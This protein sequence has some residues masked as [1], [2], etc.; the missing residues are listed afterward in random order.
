[1]NTH[2]LSKV[3]RKRLYKRW[4]LFN[5]AEKKKNSEKISYGFDALRLR[6]VQW[7]PS[8]SHSGRFTREKEI[9]VGLE[10]LFAISRQSNERAS[11]CWKWSAEHCTERGE[12][13]DDCAEGLA[14]GIPGGVLP[15]G[16]GYISDQV[17]PCDIV[18]GNWDTEFLIGCQ[19]SKRQHGG[20]HL[21][22]ASL[23]RPHTL[24]RTHI[25]KTN[26]SAKWHV[27]CETT[28][29]MTIREFPM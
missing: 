28:E 12:Y 7:L 8:L 24:T 10:R 1:M 16:Y 29:V 18:R 21:F 9:E 22:A 25:A 23:F 17:A 27:H 3:Y 13:S 20:S 2:R 5:S 15:R 26:T 4:K 6:R 11:T 19:F 14:E